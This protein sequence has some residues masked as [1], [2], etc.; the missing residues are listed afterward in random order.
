[1]QKYALMLL[2]GRV[3]LI[4]FGSVNVTVIRILPANMNYCALMH[5]K[6]N[7][8][9]PRKVNGVNWFGM[10]TMVKMLNFAL[11][12]YLR[13]LIALYLIQLIEKNKI[14]MIHYTKYIF[15]TLLFLLQ[16]FNFLS[17]IMYEEDGGFYGIE[18]PWIV[19]FDSCFHSVFSFYWIW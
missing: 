19:A 10:V 3:I 15:T 5:I 14:K 11:L 6:L 13:A 18:I 2:K 7:F 16:K 4:S 12:L 1:M 9:D 8:Y 17:Y